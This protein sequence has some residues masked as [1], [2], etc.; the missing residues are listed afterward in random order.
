MSV[1]N[2]FYNHSNNFQKYISTFF[3]S[4][5]KNHWS[6]LLLLSFGIWSSG[7]SSILLCISSSS[8]LVIH[9]FF[10][11]WLCCSISL[12]SV[13]LNMPLSL[14]F[15]CIL[16]ASFVQFFRILLTG[17]L[18]PLPEVSWIALVE[19]IPLLVAESNSSWEIILLI[20]EMPA[21]LGPGSSPVR[22]SL[23]LL[24][25]WES[26]IFSIYGFLQNSWIKRLV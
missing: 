25:D 16:F 3:L 5:H 11:I 4:K 15:G 23:E 26:L 17:C 18:L 7:S 22:R 14:H 24:T 20:V 19:A 8:K 9:Y 12:C 6:S 2:V 1:C 10:L 21:P 13:I